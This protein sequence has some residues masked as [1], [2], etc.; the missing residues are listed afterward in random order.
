[1]KNE[2]V[3]SEDRRTINTKYYEDFQRLVSDAG[4]F[5]AEEARTKGVPLVYEED[6]HIVKEYASGNKK[7]LGD[8]PPRVDVKKKVFRIPQGIW[9]DG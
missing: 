9:A 6:G 4:R 8:A 1:M 7:I 3:F 2:K 5:A